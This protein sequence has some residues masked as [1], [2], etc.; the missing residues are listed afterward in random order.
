MVHGINDSIAGFIRFLCIDGKR[1]SLAPID[2]GV[3]AVL[4]KQDDWT[5]VAVLQNKL[6]ITRASLD[7]SINMLSNELLEP[8][9]FIVTAKITGGEN[10]RENADGSKENY[11]IGVEKQV[12]LTF[13]G[14]KYVEAGCP[15]LIKDFNKF[16][17]EI[18]KELA[19]T[20]KRE[21]IEEEEN[22]KLKKIIN[23]ITK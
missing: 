20:A 9:S 8:F 22:K 17:R 4:Y 18:K 5:R 14:K 11:V 15:V 16:M 19:N 7:K 12:K 1:E 6:G 21:E 23:K 13:L 2:L 10:E 3:L